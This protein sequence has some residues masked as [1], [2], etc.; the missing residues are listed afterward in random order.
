MN[1][2]LV[3]QKLSRTDQIRW[4]N[5]I[6]RNNVTQ[7]AAILVGAGFTNDAIE[8]CLQIGENTIAMDI[9]IQARQFD[10]AENLAK[11]SGNDLKL[12]EILVLKGDLEAAARLFTRLQQFER[13]AKLYVQLKMFEEAA[14]LYIKIDQ[15]MNAVMCYQKA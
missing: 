14:V 12:A 7:A 8:Y 10:E 15:F 3:R 9:A 6:T 2:D 5:A 4:D 11:M 1:I 13:A